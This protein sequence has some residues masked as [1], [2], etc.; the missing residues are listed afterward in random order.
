MFVV[1]TFWCLDVEITRLKCY[2]EV[3]KNITVS[4]VLWKYIFKTISLQYPPL[5]ISLSLESV[6]L[7]Y[8]GQFEAKTCLYVYVHAWITTCQLSFGQALFYRYTYITKAVACL[9]SQIWGIQAKRQKT[10]I[11]QRKNFC[12]YAS[13]LRQLV[14]SPQIKNIINCIVIVT[15]AG[16]ILS[17]H[18][19]WSN[20]FICA[21]LLHWPCQRVL[22]YFN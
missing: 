4:A 15:A 18:V 1:K 14:Y 10:L 20:I 17:L 9:Y 16:V 13:I 6:R 3:C 22:I 19:L 8:I 2:K 21:I 5:H 11:K 7:F 12:I